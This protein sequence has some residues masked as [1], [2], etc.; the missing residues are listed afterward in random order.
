M[1]LYSNCRSW[2]P[3]NEQWQLADIWLLET[4]STVTKSKSHKSHVRKRL[5]IIPNL[6]KLRQETPEVKTSMG[7]TCRPRLG[8]KDSCSKYKNRS[9][10]TVNH[11]WLVTK[12][13]F[14]ESIPNLEWTELPIWTCNLP[15]CKRW[16]IWCLTRWYQHMLDAF[17]RIE[18]VVIQI[19]IILG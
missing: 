5:S 13:S 4:I 9:P 6:R 17:D 8:R 15:S 14:V 19:F 12:W 3:S 18:N 11:W 7:Y 10:S 2:L 1:K 16:S